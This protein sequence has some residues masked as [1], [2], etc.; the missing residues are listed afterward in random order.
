MSL[1]L[2]GTMNP[3]LWGR[4]RLSPVKEMLLVTE[5][6]LNTVHY[7]T[8]IQFELRKMILKHLIALTVEVC[9]KSLV[10]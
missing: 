3:G 2:S 1:C 9:N 6:T 10:Y 5:R 4:F 7:H 8:G